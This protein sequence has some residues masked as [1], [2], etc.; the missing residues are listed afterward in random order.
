MPGQWWKCRECAWFTPKGHRFCGGCGSQYQDAPN[1]A[2]RSNQKW[3]DN[4]HGTSQARPRNGE[5]SQWSGHTPKGRW[6]KWKH[7]ETTADTPEKNEYMQYVEEEVTSM[8]DQME[9]LD[10]VIAALKCRTDPVAEQLLDQS[11]D[12]LRDFRIQITKS[13]LLEN[14]LET[15]TE[16]VERR[17]LQV[18]AAGE[19]LRTAREQFDRSSME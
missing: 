9:S 16:L 3:Q 13:K 17:T 10:V 2:H 18:D 6:R 5:S 14:Q 19:H 1:G 8:K 12:Q 7:Q 15:L 11:K 4:G